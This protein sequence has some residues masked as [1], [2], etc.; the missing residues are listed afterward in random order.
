MTECATRSPLDDKS[1]RCAIFPSISGEGRGNTLAAAWSTAQTGVPLAARVRISIRSSSTGI[2]SSRHSW[3]HRQMMLVLPAGK[4]ADRQ[5]SH[6][7]RFV[8]SERS[9]NRLSAIGQF[10]GM[11][12]TPSRAKPAFRRW[13]RLLRSRFNQIVPGHDDQDERRIGSGQTALL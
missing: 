1:S 9:D 5:T 10:M 12:R 13:R 3:G 4:R 2:F 7:R 11:A 6:G 8:E